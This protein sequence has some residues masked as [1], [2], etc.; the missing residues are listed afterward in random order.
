MVNLKP[1][2]L[3]E[4]TKLGLLL[5]IWYAIIIHKFLIYCNAGEC[6]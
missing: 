2:L 5:H 1:W 3:E 4:F 6:Y